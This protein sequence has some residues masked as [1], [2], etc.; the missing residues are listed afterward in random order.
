MMEG[1]HFL[2]PRGV[3]YLNTGLATASRTIPCIFRY[4][5]YIRYA[6]SIKTFVRTENT[7]CALYIRCTLSTGKCGNN[8]QYI[9]WITDIITM[10]IKST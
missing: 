7:G 6:V 9:C 8:I 10:Y 3:K 4:A 1:G 2:G 5:V